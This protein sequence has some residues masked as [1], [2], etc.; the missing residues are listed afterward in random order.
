M[1]LLKARINLLI[2][3]INKAITKNPNLF[4]WLERPKEII[5]DLL[6]Q[7]ESI[8]VKKILDLVYEFI[9]QT[10]NKLKECRG[11]RISSRVGFTSDASYSKMTDRESNNPFVMKYSMEVTDQ[12]C[13]N[14]DDD[15]AQ[16]AK[17]IKQHLDFFNNLT[18]NYS[19]F[20]HLIK[21]SSLKL[22]QTRQPSSRNNMSYFDNSGDSFGPI[23]HLD[24]TD[25]DTTKRIKAYKSILNYK[26]NSSEIKEQDSDE[27]TVKFDVSIGDV[28]LRSKSGTKFVHSQEYNGV[29]DVIDSIY[30]NVKKLEKDIK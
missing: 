20:A 16:E 29:A 5:N 7:K 11:K 10:K 18:N 26:N 12:E 22:D 14:I 8:E 27:E 3:H 19:P 6:D 13:E 24:K 1:K 30:G 15:E 17:P 28:S 25:N 4:A 23:K 2:S 21:G 9:E